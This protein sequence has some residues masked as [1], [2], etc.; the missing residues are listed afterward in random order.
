VREEEGVTV[1][2]WFARLSGNSDDDARSSSVNPVRVVVSNDSGIIPENILLV[3]L[4]AGDV[5]ALEAMHA[6]HAADLIAYASSYVRDRDAAAD[7]V[8]DVFITIW[9]RRSTLPAAMTIRAYLYAAVRNGALKHVRHV[10]AIRRAETTAHEPDRS[11]SGDAAANAEWF[12]LRTLVRREL[13]ALPERQRAAIELRWTRRLNNSEVAAVLGVS[14]A[15]VRKLVEKALH[16]LEQ[17][18]RRLRES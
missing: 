8:Q 6:A 4:R 5:S 18:H 13:G 14:E 16:R 9:T 1:A 15:A 10:S 17:L 3:R 12:A 7:I 2:L 11:V